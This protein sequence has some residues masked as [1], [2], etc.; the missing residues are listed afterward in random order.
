M[1][2]GIAQSDK[3]GKAASLYEE[4]QY[5]E[6][7]VIWEGMVDVDSPDPDIFINIGHAAI[8]EGDIGFAVINYERA[9][10]YRPANDSIHHYIQKAR[11]RIPQSVVPIDPFFPGKWMEAFLS[12]IR[13]GVWALTGLLFICMAIIGWLG[14]LRIV[15]ISL[16]FNKHF[17]VTSLV[18][19]LIL[20]L[21]G[22]MSYAMIYRTNEAVI[23]SVCDFKEAPSDQSPL[24][25]LL[26][27]GEK[28]KIM[29]ELNE[30]Y[31]VKL[32]NLDQ[33]WIQKSCAIN[34]NPHGDS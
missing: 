32:L 25:R 10:R 12:S 11:E 17:V 26:H 1:A 27:P 30:W 2:T 9:L 24:T 13:P 19:G 7:R 3:A 33:G 5:G 23:M 18:T 20:V 34:I 28:V 14:M 8:M 4:G 31:Q 29:D 22:V 6:A 16:Q 15:S 21:F